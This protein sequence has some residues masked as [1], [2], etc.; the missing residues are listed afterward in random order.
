MLKMLMQSFH[1]LLQFMALSTPQLKFFF[2]PAYSSNTTFEILVVCHDLEKCLDVVI[3][4]SNV[5]FGTPI[6]IGL[7]PFIVHYFSKVAG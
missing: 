5:K 6:A 2:A 4:N 7:K 3:N 1:L